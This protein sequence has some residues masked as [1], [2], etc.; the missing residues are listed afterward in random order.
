MKITNIA[1]PSIAFVLILTTIAGFG[2]QS[3]KFWREIDT[4]KFI[5][6]GSNGKIM[7]ILRGKKSEAQKHNFLFSGEHTSILLVQIDTSKKF[8]FSRFTI[9]DKH[10]TWADNNFENPVKFFI[11]VDEIKKRIN[12]AEN[13]RAEQAGAGQPAT[14]PESKPEGSQKPQPESEG[15]SR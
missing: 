3:N 7:E 2:D 15:R 10:I 9:R 4:A 14:A 8:K 5:A 12:R 11:P 13:P 1:L 6:I